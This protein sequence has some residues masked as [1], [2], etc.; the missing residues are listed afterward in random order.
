ML[1]R[2]QA[3]PK[4]EWALNKKVNE[5][6]SQADKRKVRA[7][8]LE[9]TRNHEIA[10]VPIDGVFV[11][12]GH[13]PN[14]ALFRGQL[15]MDD[16]GYIKVKHGTHTSVHGVFACGDVMD[17]TYKQ[18]VTAAGTGCMAAIDAE[19]WLEAQGHG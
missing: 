3:N 8:V 1:A 9:D 18:A 15:D 12:I 17:K 13:D 14:S 11:A 7:V 10:E 16:Q 4:I 5:I 6:V 2:A 19:R